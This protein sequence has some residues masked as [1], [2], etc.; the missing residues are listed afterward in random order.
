MHDV[1]RAIQDVRQRDR[2]GEK[3]VVI[4]VTAGRSTEDRSF[5]S[6]T[7]HIYFPS[8]TSPFLAE[9]PGQEAHSA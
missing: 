9:L 2:R 1:P 8:T 6:A 7:L 4:N 5:Q 3:A